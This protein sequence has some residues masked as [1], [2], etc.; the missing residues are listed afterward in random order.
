MAETN[1][2][3]ALEELI[4]AGE[5]LVEAVNRVKQAIELI[6]QDSLPPDDRP[7]G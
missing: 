4:V 6:K 7:T 3:K 5:T 1:L 2:G